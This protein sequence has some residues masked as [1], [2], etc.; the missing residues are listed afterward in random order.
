MNEG[1]APDPSKKKSEST[2]DDPFGGMFQGKALTSANAM[3]LS[4]LVLLVAVIVSAVV[5]HIRRKRLY[6][7]VELATVE[8][9]AAIREKRR[10]L[11]ELLD[12]EYDE[13][14]PKEDR[15]ADDPYARGSRPLT[16]TAPPPSSSPPQKPLS[17][18]LILSQSP[19]PVTGDL[20]ECG[21]CGEEAPIENGS[22]DEADMTWYCNTCWRLQDEAN[23]A[24]NA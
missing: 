18:V 16:F 20:A 10:S 6:A 9:P 14:M 22:I 4:I 24:M 11:L 8:N 12:L 5:L 23:S 13:E 3:V 7:A 19:E 15:F 21:E 2:D 17:K 1:T